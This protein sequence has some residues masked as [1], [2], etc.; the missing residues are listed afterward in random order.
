[1]SLSGHFGN[2]VPFLSSCISQRE[3]RTSLVKVY[4]RAPTI[5]VNRKG[6]QPLNATGGRVNDT[7]TRCIL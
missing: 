7:E 3:A 4:F 2:V 6:E 5:L 1:M